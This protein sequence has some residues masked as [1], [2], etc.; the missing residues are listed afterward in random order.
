MNKN[1]AKEYVKEALS[2][3]LSLQNTKGLKSYE[4][5]EGHL[6]DFPKS[7]FKYRCFNKFTI[8]SIS[9]NYLYL[10]PAKEL[11]DQFECTANF[12]PSITYSNEIIEK[13][14]VEEVANM[15]SDYPSNF[16]KSEMKKLMYECLDKKSKIS[17]KKEKIDLKSSKIKSNCSSKESK[18]ILKIFGA[19]ISG[20]WMNDK[21]P[22]I[23]NDLIKKALSAKDKL[24]IGSLS[25][26]N[27]SQIM[28]D[29]YSDHYSGYCVEYDTSYDIDL[30]INTFPVVYGN[31]RQT[32]ILSIL[33]GM[34]VEGYIVNLSNNKEYTLERSLDY[35]YLIITKYKE[36]EFQKEWRIVGDAYFK[37][38]MPKIKSIYLG[39]KCTCDNEKL[40]IKLAKELGFSVYKQK[41]N[42][43]D[44]S[45]DF[46]KIYN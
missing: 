46:E 43:V 33:I 31:K 29:M 24:G 4:K 27:T 34:I 13:Y 19:L 40:I 21:T 11:D 1:R 3:R 15:I 30:K 41:D 7:L 45:I 22:D 39:K 10:S 18:E 20:M 44:L 12:D 26:I 35:F 38:P 28:W 36:W 8:D 5:Y 2:L 37:F 16:K 14:F 17:A 32:N 42:Y 23:F 25:E 6:K 9:N